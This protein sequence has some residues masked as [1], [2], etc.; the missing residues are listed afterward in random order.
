MAFLRGG[1][2]SSL[3]VRVLGI[4]STDKVY[5]ALLA[6]EGIGAVYRVRNDLQLKRL[7]RI[8]ESVAYLAEL[9]RRNSQ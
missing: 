6:T 3:A 7:R 1:D 2:P 5:V 4:V 8:P 9:H